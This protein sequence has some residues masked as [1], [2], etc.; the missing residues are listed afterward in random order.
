MLTFTKVQPLSSAKTR[1]PFED[2]HL[3]KACLSI[4][5]TYWHSHFHPSITL[6]TQP[7]GVRHYTLSFS[8]ETYAICTMLTLYPGAATFIH[9]DPSVLLETYPWSSISCIPSRFENKIH[10]CC[11][12]M[13]CHVK[14]YYTRVLHL[15]NP[16]LAS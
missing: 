11:I 5:H 2:I 8:L 7:E 6:G 10:V 4:N 12:F 9:Q 13:S 14:I 1:R 15:D 3:S 16:I